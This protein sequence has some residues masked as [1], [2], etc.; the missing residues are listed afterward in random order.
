MALCE[1]CAAELEKPAERLPAPW[2]DHVARR[3][4]GERARPTEWRLLEILWRRRD[5]FVSQ[6]SLMILLYAHRPDEAPLG[7]IIDVFVCQL[8][9][10]LALTPYSIAT[11]FGAGYRFIEPAALEAPKVGEVENGVPLPQATQCA[12]SLGDKF[13]F[14]AMQIGQSRIIENVPLNTLRAAIYRATRY[15]FGRFALAAVFLG[16]IRVWRIE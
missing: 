5:R 15:G 14:A 12:G 3:I 8:R 9:R 13:G 11:K 4:A 16:A 1:H 6:D 10:R 7:K 2:F